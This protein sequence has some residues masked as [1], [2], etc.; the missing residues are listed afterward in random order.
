MSAALSVALPGGGS[1]AF[2][3]RLV[4][5]GHMAWSAQ[6]PAG[7]RAGALLSVGKAQ[8]HVQ[9]CHQTNAPL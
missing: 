5:Q 9:Y 8:L 2:H 3:C 6:E 7:R 4:A 1:S